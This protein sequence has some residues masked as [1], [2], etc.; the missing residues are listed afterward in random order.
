MSD[1]NKITITVLYFASACD[2]TGLSSES[3]TFPLPQM[4]ICELE[5]KLKARHEKLKNIL[6]ICM[7]AVNKE[8]CGKD[9]I[10]K[11]GDEVAII[12]PVSGG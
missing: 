2:A 5:D 10:V 8:Y 1:D 11:E 12:P 6:D 7:F 3:L 9:D 4:R